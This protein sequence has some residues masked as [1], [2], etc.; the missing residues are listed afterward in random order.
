M[1]T[2]AHSIVYTPQAEAVRA[3]FRDVL[4]FEHVDAGG[5]WLIFKL[6][7]GEV[8]MH[9]S[10]GAN[11]HELF[12]TCDDIDTTVEELRGRG[13]EFAG[14][15]VDARF[16]RLITVLLPGGG[17]IGVYEPRHPTTFG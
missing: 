1:I 16:G 10:D 14:D 12:L 9:P 4:K 6:P 17:R 13:A 5:G 7:P 11:E 8:A 15:I 3:F 2:G